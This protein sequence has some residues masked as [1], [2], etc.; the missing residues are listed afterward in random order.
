MGTRL[1]LHG[2]DRFANVEFLY[3]PRLDKQNI[4][5][6]F[7]GVQWCEATRLRPAWIQ[8]FPSL[9]MK[10]NTT[11]NKASTG[12]NSEGLDEEICD[13]Q[14]FVSIPRDMLGRSKNMD[15]VILYE[16]VFEKPDM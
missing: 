16:S 12:K 4:F 14:N 8:N 10:Y 15:N 11:M 2:S 9:K 7:N 5:P 3:G 1:K 13:C 6:Y